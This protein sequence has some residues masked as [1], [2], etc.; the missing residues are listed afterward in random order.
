MVG[1]MPA[2]PTFY[3][4]VPEMRAQY[5]AMYPAS[6][7][8]VEQAYALKEAIDRQDMERESFFYNFDA[9][10]I[11]DIDTYAGADTVLVSAGASA[12]TLSSSTSESGMADM[13][14]DLDAQAAQQKTEAEQ[15]QAEIAARTATPDERVRASGAF[16]QWQLKMQGI[17]AKAGKRNIVNTYVWDGDGG[18][19]AEEQGFASTIEHSLG[20]DLTH[21]GGGGGSTDTLI[22]AV[23]LKASL[24]FS[25]SDATASSKT[26]SIG[27]AMALNVDL[28]GVE[29]DGITDLRDNPL[30]P[31]EKVD[32]Y[33]FMTFYLEGSTSHFTD[34]FRDV[35]DPE[36]LQKNGEESRALRQ[37]MTKP[38]KCW[39]VLHRVTYVER[40]TLRGFGK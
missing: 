8:R 33:R 9:S 36:W 32:R 5:G 15:R 4:H 40:P 31:G 27:R 11:Y 34:F 37:A 23:K 30:N 19:R 12:P 1:S 6:Y 2:D 14:K 28:S 17:Q 13:M 29:S 35:V 25:G 24:I 38:N 7:Y 39:R 26:L 22:A 16:A 20:S 10:A 21:G 3:P 18:L